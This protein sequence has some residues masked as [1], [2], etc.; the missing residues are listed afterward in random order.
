MLTRNLREAAE[1]GRE[2]TS[3]ITQSLS[4]PCSE[5]EEEE[6]ETEKERDGEGGHLFEFI[7]TIEDAGG[8]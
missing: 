2:P 6:E 7:D 5:A 8:R 1:R 3:R 4:L